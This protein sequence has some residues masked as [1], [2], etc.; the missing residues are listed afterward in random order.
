V[1]QQGLTIETMRELLAHA[2]PKLVPF[3]A[4]AVDST[5]ALLDW[6]HRLPS[7]ALT[8]RLHLVYDAAGR[9]R[10]RQAL[11]RRQDE[12]QARNRYPE[13]DVPDYSGL[14]S[15]EA[16]DVELSAELTVEAIRL[17]SPWRREVAAEDAQVAVGAVRKSAQFDDLQRSVGPRPPGLGDLEAVAWTPPC[18]SGLPGWTL[19]VWWRISFDGRV[20]RGWSFLVEVDLPELPVC[21]AREFSIRA[22]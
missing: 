14:P 5:F 4:H 10:F 15:D 9:E 22:G 3:R 21:A 20:G 19:D 2:M 16:Y 1:E 7:K 8:V 18:E 11:Q 12:I 17:V 13:F 6:D